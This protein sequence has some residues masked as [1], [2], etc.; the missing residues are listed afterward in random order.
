M[1]PLELGE[2][3]RPV[4][5]DGT[6][7]RTPKPRKGQ[8]LAMRSSVEVTDPH[9]YK[10]DATGAIR[11]LKR[12]RAKAEIEACKRENQAHTEVRR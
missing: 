4:A 8:I 11:S 6:P 3:K 1:G 7:K 9:N 2:A 10:R 5:I 12:M